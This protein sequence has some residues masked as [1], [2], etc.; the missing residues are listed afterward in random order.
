MTMSNPNMTNSFRLAIEIAVFVAVVVAD[1]FGLVPITQT[2]FLLPLVWLMLR[3][4]G[5]R[6][7][8]I[9]FARPDNFGWAIGVGVVAGVLME[10]FAV[11]VTT[12]LIS[13]FFGTEPNYS[14]FNAIRGNLILL[15]IFIGLSWTLAAFGE[16]ICFRG[17]LMNRLARIFGESR[18]AWIAALI[19][20]SILFGWGHT[21]QG[22]SGWIQEGLSGLILGVL[23]LISNRNLVVPIVAHGVSNTLAFVLIYFER[24]P[25]L[26]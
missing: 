11:F 9:G 22:V 8:E 19:L 3:L 15:F 25:G 10:L 26:G 16:E 21:E 6:W 24:Y 7:S 5:E 2:I 18:V 1:A 13:G 4:S 12:P 17:F 20:S 23:F 14:E